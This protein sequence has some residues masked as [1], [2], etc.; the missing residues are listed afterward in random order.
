[1]VPHIGSTNVPSHS[2]LQRLNMWSSWVK[3]KVTTE[4]IYIAK[5]KE[6]PKRLKKFLNDLE[7]VFK[8]V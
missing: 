5:L 8:M 7:K 4:V 3:K 1:V 2:T 6:G